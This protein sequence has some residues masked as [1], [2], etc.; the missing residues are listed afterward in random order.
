[1]FL[2]VSK[3][4]PTLELLGLPRPID[5]LSCTTSLSGEPPEACDDA[6]L[7]PMK[8]ACTSREATE[9]S[10]CPMFI[11]SNEAGEIVRL[12]SENARFDKDL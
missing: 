8:T 7:K 11:A 9:K 12:I 1:M 3:P 4:L 10:K 5:L 6:L 2:L